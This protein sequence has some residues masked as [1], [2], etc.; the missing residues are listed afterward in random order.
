MASDDQNGDRHENTRAA[1]YVLGVLSAAERRD[2]QRQLETD[3]A[4]RMEVNRWERRLAPLMLEIAEIEPPSQLWQRIEAGIDHG[5]IRRQV[6]WSGLTVW[7]SLAF[8]SSMLAAACLAGLVYVVAIRPPLAPL[9]PMLAEVAGAQS[10]FVAAIDP[11]SR[12]LTIVPATVGVTDLNALQLWWIAGTS[13]PRSLGLIEA[14]RPIRIVLPSDLV[15]EPNA[16]LAVSLEPP[17]GSPTGQPTG[18]VIA[19]GKITNL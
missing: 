19:S 10:K 16:T 3:S 6:R 7:K 8:G 18:P 9:R 5:K 12:S 15:L 13:K 1:E 14:A 4:L 11:N 17:G 2:V